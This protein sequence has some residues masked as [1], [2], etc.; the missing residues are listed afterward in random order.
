[1]KIEL[2]NYTKT[3]KVSTNAQEAFK[4]LTEQLHLWW[5]KTSN[6][7]FKT[8]GHFTIQF[9]NEY[10]WTFKILEYTPNKELIWKCIEG[11]PEFNKEWI[12][13]ILH[14]T[15]EENN[16]TTTIG[17]EQTG[18]TKELQCYDVCTSTWNM[19]LGERLKHFLENKKTQV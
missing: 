9:E 12:G 5:G 1:M 10:W 19:F 7:E 18:L 11:E 4:A 15:I 6:C 8:D 13:N 3:V 17:F 14:W 16:S 2:D